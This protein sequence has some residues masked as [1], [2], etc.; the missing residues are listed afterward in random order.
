MIW[1][2]KTKEALG[3]IQIAVI[4]VFGNPDC[5]DKHRLAM[6]SHKLGGEK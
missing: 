2:R 4:L 5:F 1:D 3:A 6:T